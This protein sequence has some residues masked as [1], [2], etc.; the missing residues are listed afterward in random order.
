MQLKYRPLVQSLM[1][2]LLAAGFVP[3]RATHGEPK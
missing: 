1:A 3:L 2:V